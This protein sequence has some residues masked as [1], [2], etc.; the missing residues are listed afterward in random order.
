M[1]TETTAAPPSLLDAD[2][3]HWKS[4][5]H[6][7]DFRCHK[8]L[9]DLGTYSSFNPEHDEQ[10]HVLLTVHTHPFSLGLKLPPNATRALAQNLMAAAG[11]AEAVEQHRL[12]LAN[13]QA[14]QQSGG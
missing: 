11:H 4:H 6:T 7:P 3:S 14:T 8:E 10:T 9:Q 12:H 2:G 5:H 13:Q 1:S